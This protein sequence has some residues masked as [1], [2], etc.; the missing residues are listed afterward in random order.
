MLKNFIT[1]LFLGI[2]CA[3]FANRTD[4]KINN[5]WKFSFRNQ[6]PQSEKL[7]HLPHTW[8]ALDADATPVYYR[9]T[10]YY[11][12]KLFIDNR[13]RGKRLFLRFEGAFSVTNVFMN[14]KH[15]GEHRGGY[16]A[17]VFEI[18][19]FVNYGEYNELR[20]NVD[21]SLQLDVM[22]L[23]GDFNFYGGIYR[24]VH[25]VITD[26]VNI[27]LTD[28]ASP[29][30]YITQKKVTKK[31]AEVSVKVCLS[32]SCNNSENRSLRVR[33]MNNEKK[34]CEQKRNISIVKGESSASF[35]FYINNPRLWNGVTDPFMYQV[36][37]SLLD[38]GK[39]SDQIVQPLGLRYY[40]I[41]SDKGLFLN[42][43]HL[44][45]HGVC[46]HQE[47]SEVGNAL[48]KEHH[49]EDIALIVEMGANAV[50]LAHYPQSTYTYD[51][52]DKYGLITWAEIPFVGPAGEIDR[53]YTNMDSFKK[54][55]K[56]QLVELIRQHYNHP[57][58]FFW[59]LFNELKFDGDNPTEYI[60]ELNDLAHK[61][62]HTRLTTAATNRS[63]KE[64]VNKVPDL[65]AWNQYFGWYGG[66]AKTLGSFLDDTHAQ[67]PDLKIG[68][69]EYGAGASIWH[70]QDS[71]KIGKVSG[72][73]HPENYQTYCHMESWKAIAERP[74]VWG[75]FI[76]NMF[77]F[78]S[79]H[80]TEG[81]R[82]GINDKG[83]VTRDRKVKKDAFYF[84]KA[85][86][87]TKIPMVYIANRRHN[88]RTANVTDV[89][90]FS[91]QPEVELFV[92]GIS[93]GTMKKDGFAVFRSNGVMLKQGKNLV[94]VKCMGKVKNLTDS[95]VWNVNTASGGL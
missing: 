31:D 54:N 81:D 25:L 51:L 37:V 24:D 60:M 41:D 83:L 34:V 55:G 87:N 40:T 80:R 63:A 21:N 5:D 20:V 56:Q 23:G 35:D 29:G 46:R 59:G 53:G 32:N 78:G 39:L 62:D 26:K 13:W 9:G 22:P 48:H 92:N 49:D 67:H 85:N 76:W 1:T 7:V 93:Q 84:Y 64:P 42:G 10:A 28:F 45:L 82:S 43:E 57:S 95:V 3:A 52:M 61:E 88:E 77:D 30:V 66:D 89:M 14:K 2:F 33:I 38:N 4:I 50:R 75:T 68:L 91:N 72:Y 16:G 86:W 15:L 36:E 47:R 18:T 71:V 12:K 65:I 44:P 8:N 79:A 6:A 73:W 70:Q 90:V 94:E 58:I 11:T 19:D 27:S 17:F 69:S 74:F